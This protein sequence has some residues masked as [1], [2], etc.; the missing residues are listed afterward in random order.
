MRAWL[1]R[2][3]QATTAVNLLRLVEELE[4]Q[5]PHPGLRNSRDLPTPEE[6]TAVLA[7]IEK[8]RRGWGEPE[9]GYRRHAA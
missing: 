9:F 4:R 8:E 1:V 3:M 6:L 7:R 5:A 2:R